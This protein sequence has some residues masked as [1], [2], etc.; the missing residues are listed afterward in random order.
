[1]SEEMHPVFGL[2]SWGNEHKHLRDPASISLGLLHGLGHRGWVAL[3]TAHPAHRTGPVRLEAPCWWRWSSSME[4]GDVDQHEPLV[5]FGS[6]ERFG[7]QTD[8]PNTDVGYFR[9][10]DG[11]LWIRAQIKLKPLGFSV[12]C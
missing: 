1:M 6:Q 11:G 8:W 12:G 4:Q 10:P 5:W 2:K 7:R 3:I 9:F